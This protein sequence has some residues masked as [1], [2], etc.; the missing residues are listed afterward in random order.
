MQII[1]DKSF[2]TRKISAKSINFNNSSNENSS[3]G[4]VSQDNSSISLSYSTAKI[5]I[6]SENKEQLKE[7]FPVKKFSK[8]ILISVA[9]ASTIGGCATLTGTGTNLIFTG[10]LETYF[11]MIVSVFNNYFSKST[12]V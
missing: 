1:L 8:M 11:N 9:Y 12:I 4:S 6:P 5:F 7:V 3:K 10:F 2:F